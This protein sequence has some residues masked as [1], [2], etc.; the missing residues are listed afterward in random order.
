MLLG[1][2]SN[3]PLVDVILA[4]GLTWAAH[5]SVAVI[6]LIM[7][8]GGKQ[9]RAARCRFRPRARR[10]SRHGD[11][12]RARRRHGRRPG[13]QAPAAGQS[14]Q[15]R[16]RRYP[17]PDRPAHHRGLGSSPSSPTRP[18]PWPIFHTAF[19]LLLAGVFFPLLKPYAGLLRRLLPARIDPADPAQP[20]YLAA[21]AS[22]APVIAIGAAAREALRLADILETMLTGLRDAFTRGDR[23]A[24][25]RNQTPR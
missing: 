18:A 5:S 21:V 13:R 17:R 23:R 6:L 20:M 8:F 19:N 10:Q 1:A 7:S 15:S 16:R 9:R 25:R 22:E 4:A 11:Q 24:D 3:Q 14:A 12:P 2:V